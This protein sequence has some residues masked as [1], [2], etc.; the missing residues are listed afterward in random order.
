MT[1]FVWRNRV[2]I[3]LACCTPLLTV[4]CTQIRPGVTIVNGAVV[5]HV[6]E[7]PEQ[8]MR[9]ADEAFVDMGYVIASERTDSAPLRITAHNAQGTQFTFLLVNGP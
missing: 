6:A 3:G 9:A 7:P 4:S 8:V 2:G 1:T 5:Q